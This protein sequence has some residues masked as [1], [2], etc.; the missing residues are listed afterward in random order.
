MM[1]A[2]VVSCDGMPSVASH[3]DW[4]AALAAVILAF[5]FQAPVL[6]HNSVYR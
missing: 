6:L 1:V 5:W 4:L 2:R 3:P